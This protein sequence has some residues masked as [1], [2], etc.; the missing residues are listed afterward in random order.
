MSDKK[1]IQHCTQQQKNMLV[2]LLKDEKYSQLI[3]GKF[4]ASFTFEH[5]KGK[6]E[7]ITEIL[8]SVP[9]AR[10]DWKQWRKTWQD[11]RSKTKKRKSEQIKYVHRTGGGPSY[12]EVLDD[13]E[14]KILSTICPVAISGNDVDESIVSFTFPDELMKDQVVEIGQNDTHLQDLG[15]LAENS[16]HTYSIPNTL[17]SDISFNPSKTKR[18][19]ASQRLLSSATATTTLADIAKR[20]LAVKEEYLHK[21]LILLERQVCAVENLVEVLKNKNI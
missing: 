17:E 9:G 21:K 14:E 3:S 10:K 1:I 6:W 4:K 19:V 18:T 2:D 15:N 7:E 5:A 13:V 12:T 20:K 16:E 8:N 11:F